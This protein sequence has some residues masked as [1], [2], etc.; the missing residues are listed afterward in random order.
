MTSL[1]DRLIPA[2]RLLE[3]DHVDLAVVPER[4]WDRIRHQD[5]AQ[6]PLVQAFFELRAIPERFSGKHQPTSLKL[7][8]LRS[9]PQAP[10]FSLLLEEPGHEFAVGAIGKVWHPVIEF[11]H[12]AGAAAFM[13]FSEPD[14]VKVAWS[15]RAL[16]LGDHGCRVEV[17]VRVDA[18][19]DQAWRKFERYFR[20]IGPGSHLIRRVLLRSLAKELGTPDSV[21]SLR[22]LPGDELLPTASAE[23]TEGITLQAT[24]EQIW[25]WLLQM[26]CQRAGFYSVDL[27][28]NAGRRSSLELV[29]ELQQL[30]VGQVIPA[31]PEGHEGF[32]VLSIDAPHSLVLGG[33][34]DAEAKTQLPFR[35]PRPER[36]WQT[37]WAFALERLDERST[38]L[39]VRARAAF[40]ESGRFHAL[41]IR[42]VHHFMQQQML[43]HLAVRVEQR[44]RPNDYRDVL[45]GAGGAALMLAA[46]LT[47]FLRR[48]RS[49]WGVEPSEAASARPGDDLVPEPLWSWTHG[50][51]IQA[52]PELVW[53]WIAQIGADRGGFYSYQWLENLA[54]C[55]LRNADA[56]HQD[57]ELELG[58]S[59]VLHPQ[60]P[61]LRVALLERGRHFVAHA[62]ED[63][64][65]RRAGKPWASAS[66]LF[67]IEPRADGTCRLITRYRVA[68]SSDLATRLALGPTLLEPIGFAMDRR[69]LLGIKERAERQAHYALTTSRSSATSRDVPPPQETDDANSK[70][71]ATVRA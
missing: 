70:G 39:H 60:A 37:T 17:E 42:P 50:I 61:A 45:A 22:A 46:L 31:E 28:D 33:L 7:D 27:L 26:G 69:M 43:E 18:T 20:L 24:P 36:F 47:P 10:G 65:A 13:E 48:K 67:Q 59:L 23:V 14:E 8:E 41:W 53:H 19:D 40:P 16:P 55:G 51:E 15:I 11:R 5:L 2:P 30:A 54:G 57:W 64:S 38:R 34:Y 44:L 6:S 9:T 71:R 1:L 56:I 25:P 62:A 52:S 3:V 68:C 58:D 21:E 12:V 35:A 29:P 63:A 49:H 32:E 4:V 66:W